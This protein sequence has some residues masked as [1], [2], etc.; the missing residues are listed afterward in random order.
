MNFRTFLKA[1]SFFFVPYALLLLAASV[2]QVLYRQ[3]I[4]S[5]WVN[6]A[7]S[8]LADAV[9][10]YVTHLGDGRFCAAV[11]LLALLWSRRRGALIL[12]AFVVSGL[13]SQLI[14]TQFFATEPRPAQYFAK[15][16]GYLH[17]VEGV[18]LHLWHSFPSGHTASAFALYAL[19][20]FW[21]TNRA[22][23]LVWL[24]VAVA[25]A[26]SRMY[27]LQHFLV[28]VYAGSLLGTGV[29]VIFYHQFSTNND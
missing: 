29:A 27:L 1:Q 16:L 4:V 22:F 13:I 24:A 12:G 23:K 8:H 5:L 6:R 20:A 26:Y 21:T 15:M 17:R 7:H 2:L 14:K 9:F 18:E 28:D 19:L 11:G 10:P 25:V 3:G